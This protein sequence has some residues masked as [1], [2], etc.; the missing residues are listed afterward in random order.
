L[1]VSTFS[2]P[3]AR[4]IYLSPHLDDAVLSCGGLIARQ[5]SRGETVVII[6]VFA[7]SPSPD[8]S[9]SPF[10]GSL[11]ARWLAALPPDL[12]V[13]DWPALRRMEDGRA[14]ARLGPAVRVVHWPL[15][16][17]IYRRGGQSGDPLYASEAAIFGEPHPDD[18]AWRALQPGP[19]LPPDALVYAPLAVGCHVDHQIVHQAV[20]GWRLPLNQVRFYEDYPYAAGYS[21]ADSAAPPALGWRSELIHLDEAA[22][23]AKIA[24]V[25]EYRSQISTFWRGLEDMRASLRD[26][27]AR[28]GGER[29]WSRQD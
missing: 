17:C 21:A 29:L 8:Q 4:H 9:F 22:L 23:E 25:A 3:A 18:P 15:P 5:A 6:T 27:A 14:A 1:R 2:W 26:Y 19:S 10:A 13:D 11:H 16:D 7:G 24:A 20:M 12:S 28:V